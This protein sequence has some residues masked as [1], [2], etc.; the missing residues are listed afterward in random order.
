MN[1]L[2]KAIRMCDDMYILVH[3]GKSIKAFQSVG[4]P[5]KEA[6]EYMKKN[7]IKGHAVLRNNRTNNTF[8]IE[9]R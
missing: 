7:N 9:N 2:D 1:S 5:V 4:A 8:I 6:K 3:E